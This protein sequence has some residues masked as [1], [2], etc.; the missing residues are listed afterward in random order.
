MQGR[1]GKIALRHWL[2]RHCPEAQAFAKKKGFSVPVGDWIRRRG[3]AVGELVA[4]APGIVEVCRP[5]AV[6]ELFKRP[7]RKTGI[8]AWSLLFY[9]LWH[10]IHIEG[11][12][13]VNDTFEFLATN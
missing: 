13:P 12:E 10:A 9:A 4:A 6:R 11:R 7:T 1:L 5:E 3:A 8:A 2:Q